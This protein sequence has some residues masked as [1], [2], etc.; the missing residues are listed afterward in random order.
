MCDQLVQVAQEFVRGQVEGGEVVHGGAQPAHGGGGVET[1]A[2]DVADHQGHPGARQRDDVEPVTAHPGLGGQIAVRDLDGGL[3]RHA[4]GQQAALQGHGH[5]VL[6]GVAA[7]IVDGQCRP[8]GQLF[9][10]GHVLVVERRGVLP[11][12]VADHAQHHAP[13]AQGYD[14]QGVDAAVQDLQGVGLVLGPPA[15]GGAQVHLQDRTSAGQPGGHGS[16]GPEP[17]QLADGCERVVALKADD[18]GAA[19]LGDHFG[20]F[21]AAQ[22]RVQQVD[23]DHVGEPRDRHLR[24]FL[25]GA[26][27]VQR[28]TDLHP[29]VVQQLQPLASHLGPAG[30]CPQLGG[31]AQGDDGPGLPVGGGGPDVHRQQPIGRHVQLVGCGTARRD[32]IGDPLLQTQVRDGESFRVRRQVQQPPRLVIGQQQPS[33]AADDQYALAHRVQHRVV[34]FVHAGHLGRSQAVGPAQQPTAHQSRPA[35]RQG[36]HGG[37]GAEHDRQLSVHHALDVLDRDRGGDDGDDFPVGVLDGDDRD[38]GLPQGPGERLGEG[39]AGRRL[40]ERAD[41]ALSDLPRV[42][43]GEGDPVECV[44]VDPVDPGDLPGRLGARLKHRAG[45]GAAHGGDDPRRLRERS[46]GGEGTVPGVQHGGTPGLHDER[47]DRGGDEKDHD[48]QL[49]EEHL[50]GHAAHAQQGGKTLWP[51]RPSLGGWGVILALLAVP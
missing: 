47:H 13:G 42:T 2:D 51:P 3:L 15:V 48:G 38:H 5:V 17:D 44:H 20:R 27:H 30:E 4:P 21:L 1:V 14:D 12:P 37:C 10:E 35:R 16:G 28:R 11:P 31:V 29:R 39:L 45:V 40:G 26:F 24:Q 34:V 36:E 7:G 41:D 19:H 46:G 25:R 23:R 33:A 8:G 32:R 43:V 6:A 22:H 49:E 9:D 18:G 50:S